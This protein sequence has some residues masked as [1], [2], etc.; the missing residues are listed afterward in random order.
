[1]NKKN[2]RIWIVT[3]YGSLF[4]CVFVVS[5]CESFFDCT[6]KLV[7]TGSGTGTA[8]IAAKNVHDFFCVLAFNQSGDCFQVAVAS[9][10]ERNI[11]KN[12]V[13]KIKRD[14]GGAGTFGSVC[15]LHWENPFSLLV[16][17]I[18]SCLL[19]C[20][21]NGD[22]GSY[23]I[24][25]QLA[26]IAF[27]ADVVVGGADG[28]TIDVDKPSGSLD[29]QIQTLGLGDG[30]DGDGTGAADD[31]AVAGTAEQICCHLKIIGVDREV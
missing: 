23:R 12:T 2:C 7:C 21:A 20:S 27:R 3:G 16:G 19:S 22:I 1:M 9:A 14:G 26:G 5:A 29:F 25:N 30:I 18:T 8:G 28:L 24:D 11:G 6:G 17:A 31:F 13:R 10:G 15:I 4:L